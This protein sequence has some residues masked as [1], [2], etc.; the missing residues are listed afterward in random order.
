MRPI[1]VGYFLLFCGLLSWAPAPGIHA[2]S[3]FAPR[4]F[5]L[6]QTMDLLDAAGDGRGVFRWDPFFQEGSFAIGGHHGIFSTAFFPGETGFL[7]LNN[8]DVYT[9]P[10]PYFNGIELV[11]PEDFV[12]VAQEAFLRHARDNFH[13]RI[14]A[15]VI[16]P[17]HGG[18]DPGAVFYHTINGQRRLVRES[19]LVLTASKMLR[20]MLVRRY[21]DKRILMT[22]ERDVFISLADRAVIANS[23]PVRDNEAVI[24]ISMHA[25]AAMN[26]N[27]RGFEVWHLTPTYRRQLLDEEQFPDAYLRQI[28]NL[29]TEESFLTEGIMLA[30]AILDG[31]DGTM[32]RQMPNRGL[33]AEDWFVVRR[34]NMPAVLV[35]MGFITNREDA[36]LMANDASLRRIVEGVYRGITEFV[37]AFERTGGF[38]IAQ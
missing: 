11:F 5:T 21:P 6:D 36:I 9:V 26:R 32:G 4:F 16:D 24:F 8:R 23:V 2:Q 17:G 33:R 14:A 18:R 22:R 34:S 10:L 3:G 31:I 29:L 13:Y 28:L 1:R 7:M 38:I 27:A 12:M 30:Q 37:T 35:E 20:D 25:N 19:D 15:I